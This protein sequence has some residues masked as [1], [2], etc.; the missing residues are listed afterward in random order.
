MSL[1][2]RRAQADEAWWG[3]SAEVQK[4]SESA[5]E[6]ERMSTLLRRQLSDGAYSYLFSEGPSM[7]PS[8]MPTPLPSPAP[9]GLGVAATT[10]VPTPGCE[11]GESLYVRRADTFSDE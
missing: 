5:A 10:G 2:V 7:M 3:R 1:D 4:K 9:S 11:D 6:L 8:P